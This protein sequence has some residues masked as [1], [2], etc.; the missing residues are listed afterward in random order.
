MGKGMGK[1]HCQESLPE[2]QSLPD[3]KKRAESKIWAERGN[4]PLEAE[5]CALRDTGLEGAIRWPLCAA[6]LWCSAGPYRG[7]L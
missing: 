1:E 6:V 4:G 7:T 3:P 5:H 2:L